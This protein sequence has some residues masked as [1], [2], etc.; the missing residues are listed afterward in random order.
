MINISIH[1]LRI[2]KKI[3]WLIVYLD[4]D[5][6]DNIQSNLIILKT[7]GNKVLNLFGW[8]KFFC[9]IYLKYSKVLII[10]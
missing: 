8:L 6:P 1:I 2:K 5:L 3:L 9:L 4:N 10:F 7:K